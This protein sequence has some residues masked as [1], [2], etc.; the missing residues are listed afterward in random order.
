LHF[1]G[2]FFGPAAIWNLIRVVVAAETPSVSGVEYEL[3]G[4]NV[5]TPHDRITC[6][7]PAGVG[8]RLRGILH[9]GN[10]STTR[11]ADHFNYSV[12]EVAQVN[13]LTRDGLMSTI[14]GEPVDVWGRFFGPADNDRN[15]GTY[16]WRGTAFRAC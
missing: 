7:V 5:T 10:Q 9:V 2:D 8:S 3:L 6:T 13:V 14:G 12:P 11:T 15:A 16:S 4:C 1:L